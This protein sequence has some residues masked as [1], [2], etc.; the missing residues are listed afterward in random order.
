M[1]ISAPASPPEP[2]GANRKAVGLLL[3]PGTGRLA[4]L[5][6]VGVPLIIFL[7]VGFMT[8]SSDNTNTGNPY[9]NGQYPFGLGSTSGDNSGQ[10]SPSPSPSPSPSAVATVTDSSSPS[11]FDSSSDTASASAS[12]SATDSASATAT[13]TAS[14]PAATVLE[15]YADV[16][17]HDYQSAYSLGLDN[18][19]E[20]YTVFAQT[21]AQYSSI[22]LSI[23][24]VQGDVVTASLSITYTTGQTQTASGTYTVSGG[25]ITNDQVQ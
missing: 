10:S 2:R 8:T 13:S 17:R 4:A 23:A 16:N 12:A 21:Y 6:I 1:T 15:A 18:N 7:I 9:S 11:V 22:Q 20:T 19:V 14:G 3:A 5:A 25:V 24:S